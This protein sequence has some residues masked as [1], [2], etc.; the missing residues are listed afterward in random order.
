MTPVP[1]IFLP[2]LLCNEHQYRGV[3]DALGGRIDGQVLVSSRPR[4]VD[5]VVEILERAPARFALVGSS[6]GGTL[7]MEVALA[8]PQR[9]TSLWLMGCDPGAAP[10]GGPDLAGALQTN[11]DAI[12]GK[13]SEIAVFTGATAASA[14]FKSMARAVGATEGAMQARAYAAR[15]D[16]RARLHQLKMP[17]LLLWG[18]HDAL[19]PLRT[20]QALAKALPQAHFE[21]FP[22]CGHLPT[23]EKPAE[24]AALFGAFLRARYA[25]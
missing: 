25:S 4:I 24:S 20:G 1:T 22:E 6:M 23:L 17:A 10:A 5:S 21:Q 3:I 12:I 2:A 15:G 18:Q 14:S 19:V 11:P 16:L 9:V 7:A 13:L 8:A